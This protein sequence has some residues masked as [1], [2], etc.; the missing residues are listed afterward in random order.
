M[1]IDFLTIVSE[2]LLSKIFALPIFDE[3]PPNVS[4]FPL[5]SLLLFS[6][7]LPIF[8]TS[9]T[10]LRHRRH[11]VL[12]TLALQVLA[13]NFHE[14]SYGRF[15]SFRYHTCCA[16]AVS[17]L[18]ALLLKDCRCRSLNSVARPTYFLGPSLLLTVLTVAS[19]SR[20]SQTGRIQ[21]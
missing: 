19:C 16:R 21:L 20:R 6:L 3:V 11:V 9:A 12:P 13:R 14:I 5:I 2:Q 17:S 18:L 1:Q 4:H 15:L 10:S 8:S 7:F